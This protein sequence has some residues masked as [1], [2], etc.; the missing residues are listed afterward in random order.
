MI[1]INPIVAL[2]V[3]TRPDCLPDET[4]RLLGELNK[5]KPVW[6][7]LG[8]QS[9]HKQTAEYIRRGYS[10]DVYDAAVEKP[11][12]TESYRYEYKWD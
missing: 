6:V 7:E 2:S 11:E 10:L 9:I 12:W 1:P 3:A 4:V 8:L 5:I